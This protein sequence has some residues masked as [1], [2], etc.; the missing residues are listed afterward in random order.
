MNKYITCT[1]FHDGDKYE[2]MVSIPDEAHGIT[3]YVTENMDSKMSEGQIIEKETAPICCLHSKE[4]K[5]NYEGKWLCCDYTI[6]G[7]FCQEVALY[8]SSDT[9]TMIRKNQFDVVNFFDASNGYPQH[10]GE[11]KYRYKNGLEA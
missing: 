8:L 11:Y 5:N 4:L 3:W 1:K 2:V 6:N 7:R 9:L 10:E